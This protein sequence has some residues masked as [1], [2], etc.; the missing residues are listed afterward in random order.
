MLSCRAY[1]RGSLFS[2]GL[3]IG[4][5]FSLQNGCVCLRFI[6]AYFRKGLFLG[7]GGLIIG[8]VRYVSEEAEIILN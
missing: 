6:G 1:F 7:L 8:I 3:I 2:D 5:N 4:L